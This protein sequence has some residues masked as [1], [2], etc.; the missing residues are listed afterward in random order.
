MLNVP[1]KAWSVKRISTLASIIG[2]PII[3]DE[4]TIKICVTGVGRIGFARVLVEIDAE[5]GIKDKIKIM[6]R[7]S[8]CRTK[9]KNVIGVDKIK[10]NGNG[11]KEVQNRRYGR[12]GFVINRRTEAQNGQKS[13]MRRK[14]NEVKEKD[15]NGGTEKKSI[16]NEMNTKNEKANDEKKEFKDSQKSEEMKRY[17]RDKK[18]LIDAAKEMKE[19]EDV[20]DENDD[21]ENTVLRNE[22][23]MNGKKEIMERLRNPEENHLWNTLGHSSEANILGPDGYSRF[24]KTAWSIV[25]K[26]VSQDVREFFN[27]RKLLG[28]VNATLISLVPKIPIPGGRGLRQWDP[29]S[30]YLFTLVMEVLNLIIRKNIEENAELKYHYGCKKLEISHLCFADD[31][32]VFCQRDCDSVRIMKKSLD[33]FNNYSCILPN[34]QKSTVFFRGL[35]NAEQQSI[36]NI[37]PFSVGK[38]HVR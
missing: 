18:E 17:Y 31:L 33:E 12:E 23:L 24:Y 30:S 20:L 1:I 26:E 15:V 36:L 28:E 9:S 10:E 37:I 25:G 8:Y 13:K 11:F 34:M 16:I 32:L 2:K 5:K 6:Y 19:N 21:V 14:E 3:M 35:S 7:N 4:V 22:Q 27:T 38:R 29:I